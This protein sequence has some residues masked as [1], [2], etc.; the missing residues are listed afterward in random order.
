M[1]ATLGAQKEEQRPLAKFGEDYKFY[2]REVPM[3]FPSFK[4]L[5]GL[6]GVET[7]G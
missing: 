5:I 7:R 2:M 3:F 1:E 4:S 6:M